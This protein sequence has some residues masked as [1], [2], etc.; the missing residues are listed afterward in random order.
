MM[1]PHGIKWLTQDADNVVDLCR[2]RERGT[3]NV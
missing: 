2:A 1:L 3:E